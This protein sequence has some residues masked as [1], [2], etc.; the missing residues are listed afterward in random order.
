MT[1]HPRLFAGILTLC[2]D[3]PIVRAEPASNPAAGV[4]RAA[5]ATLNGGGHATPAGAATGPAPPGNPSPATAPA[6]GN[7]PAARY[8]PLDA[9]GQAIPLIERGGKAV[10]ATTPRCVTVK[11]QRLTWEVK[12][13]DGGLQDQNWSYT[14]FDGT[15]GVTGHPVSC[16]G[17]LGE[18]GCDTLSYVAAINARGLCGFPGG[19]RLPTPKELLGLVDDA[20]VAPAIDPDFFPNTRSARYWSGKPF[21]DDPSNAWL[22][23]FLNGSMSYRF[24]AHL[25][26]VRLVH[27]G[28]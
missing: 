22:V 1:Q 19:W 20:H 27:D 5:P 3:H 12:T 16:G 14:W 10:P 18:A 28:P 9:A 26:H 7:A 6:P 8:V 25:C 11:E 24:A 13:A 23:F 17:T 21:L 4:P 15:L 2:L